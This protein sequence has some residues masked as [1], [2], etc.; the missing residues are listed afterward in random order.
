[1]N[2]ANGMNTMNG[3]SNIVWREWYG[4]IWHGIFR[5]VDVVMSPLSS[6]SPLLWCTLL[7]MSS[8]QYRVCVTKHRN[9]HPNPNLNPNLLSSHHPNTSTSIDTDPSDLTILCTYPFIPKSSRQAK[10]ASGHVWGRP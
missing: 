9:A 5:G 6:M 7:R 1:M 2:R 10:R 8:T 3:A 4:I